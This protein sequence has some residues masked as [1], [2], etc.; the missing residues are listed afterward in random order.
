METG[1]QGLSDLDI[2]MWCAAC[3]AEEEVPDLIAQARAVESMYLELR[4]QTRA[5]LKQLV[6]SVAAAH[7]RTD[8]FLEEAKKARNST[9]W[10]FALALGLR[11][12]EALG[13]MWSDVDL[14][15]GS[16]RIRR[17]RVR[18]KYEHGCGGQCAG[19]M[20]AIARSGVRSGRR[21]RTRSR[22]LGAGV[23]ACLMSS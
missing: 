19:S 17:S 16:L 22:R 23:W 9:R 7:E 13:L 15:K 8:R 4:R 5:G 21:S 10:A 20:L 18:P 1:V 12:G 2:R 3:A 14:E 6:Q 11:Q